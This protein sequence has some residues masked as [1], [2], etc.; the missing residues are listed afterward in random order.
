MAPPTERHTG[1]G[2]GLGA[3]IPQTSPA[4]AAPVEI[5]ISRIKAIHTSRA[6]ASSNRLSS[7]SPPAS[8]ST[9]CSSRCS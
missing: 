9:A 3:L 8:P 1:L 6:N 4:G 7:N 2:K 5:P